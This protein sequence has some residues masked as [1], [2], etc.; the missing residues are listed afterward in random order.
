MDRLACRPK[1]HE[2]S[3][4]QQFFS[5]RKAHQNLYK[6]PKAIPSDNINLG[7]KELSSMNI[8]EFL[9]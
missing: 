5:Q 3:T 1:H 8:F 9:P 7:Q 2:N 4:D 6:N